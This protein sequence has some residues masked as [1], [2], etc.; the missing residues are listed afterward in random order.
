ML[1]RLFSRFF[2]G[3]CA[4]T[5]IAVG[6]S[7]YLGCRGMEGVGQIAGAVFFT[8][9]L[10]CI[11]LQGYS[12]YTGKIGFI[13]EKHDG[14]ALSVLFL[15]LA[16]NL[17]AVFLWGLA[18]RYAVPNIADAAES[19]ATTKLTQGFFQTLIRAVLCGILMYLAVTVWRDKGRVVAILFCV[20]TFILA[21]FEHSIADFFYFSAAAEFTASMWLFI[22]AALIGNS[23]GA[24][25]LPLLA[26]SG[27]DRQQRN[28]ARKEKGEQEGS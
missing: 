22:L 8:V 24:M 20:P 2:S 10:L 23:L 21:G 7:V 13:P 16:G 17:T 25:L 28:P 4:G 18:V 6:G 12:L 5:L 26:A 14:E 27:R 11:C 9:A 15:G 19:V 3:V 1:R